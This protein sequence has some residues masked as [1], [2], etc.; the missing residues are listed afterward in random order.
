MKAV[1][2]LGVALTAL[3]VASG[4]AAA[5]LSAQDQTFIQQAALGG[6]SEVQAGQLAES[7]AQTP[8]VK[9]FGQHMIAD[10]TPNNQELATLATQKGVTAPTKLDAFHAQQAA[11]LQIQTGAAFDKAYIADEIAGHQ[12]MAQLMQD[13]I[14]S[15]TD[16]DLK[17]FAQKTMPVVQEHLTMA[18]QLAGKT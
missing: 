4:M 14:A 6:L 11:S 9:Q 18:Q 10:H 15:G 3:P 17:A 1:V 13:E 7:K 2:L 16:P 12:Q 5:T 8:A